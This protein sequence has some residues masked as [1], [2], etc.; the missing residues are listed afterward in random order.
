MSRYLYEH[1]F[2]GHLC[3]EADSRAA[4]FASSGPPLRAA[5]RCSHCHASPVRRPRRR[6]LF[7]P[8]R[9]R[10][11]SASRKDAHALCARAGTHGEVPGLVPRPA[12]TVA[13]LPS[14]D[15]DTSSNP[16]AAFRGIPLDGRYRF[17]LDEAEYFMMNFI[18]GP[19]CRGQLALDVIEDRF[20][21][22]FV[23]PNVGDD[24]MVAELLARQ[25]SNLRL[26]AEWGSTSLALIAVAAILEAPN[27]LP[28]GE[29]R[30][31]RTQ[32]R[33]RARTISR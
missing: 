33:W 19:V 12:Y 32:T 7:L 25:R 4:R 3:F 26:P 18:K 28:A 14:F 5:S 23:D 24:V 8:T 9:A 27:Q 1:L 15:A 13:A 11:R 22:Y 30:V 2:L 31:A 17:M 6:A 16:F 21:V 20:W 29:E 10:T